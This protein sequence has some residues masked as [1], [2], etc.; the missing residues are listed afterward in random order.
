[1]GIDLEEHDLIE[2]QQ[3]DL[4]F[5]FAKSIRYHAYRRSFWQAL[6]HW[7]KILSVITGTAVVVTALGNYGSTSKVMAIGVALTS[8]ADVIFGFG[9]RANRHDNLYRDWCRL[10][11]RLLE[12]TELSL[13]DIA[14]FK[15]KRLRIE[16]DEPGVIDLLERRC[17]AEET[18]AR[19]QEPR[20]SQ[21]L[22]KFQTIFSQWAM[23][24]T[25][26]KLDT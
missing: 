11:Q 1:M 12:K 26:P 8:A 17:A 13:G 4:D 23:W 5:S 3:W 15:A 10:Q 21:K 25:P 19:G 14:K 6:D 7:S 9:D 18:I 22:T 20:N 16:R 2:D 24:P